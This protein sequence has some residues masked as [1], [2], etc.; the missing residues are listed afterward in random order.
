MKSYQGGVLFIDMLGFGALTNGHLTLGAVECEPWKVDPN[1]ASPHQLI[2]AQILL[3]FR[4]ALMRTKNAYKAVRVAQLSDAAFLWSEDIG[5][6]A[7]A[8][9]YVM[10]EAAAMGLLCRGGLAIGGVHEPNKPNN[11]LGA[12]IVGD[13]VTRAVS[14]EGKGKGMRIFTD[15]DTVRHVLEARPDEVFTP[16]VD[17]LSG[18]TIDEWQWYVPS[19]LLREE[20]DKNKLQSQI[21]S[22]VTCH[23]MFRYSPKLSW[24]ATTSEGRRQIACSVVAVSD[25]MQRLSRNKGNFGFSVEH[26]MLANQG[27]SERTRQR[28]HETFVQ[29]L[30]RAIQPK[31]RK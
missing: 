2:A 11:S 27:R 23:T 7:D 14:H 1:G 18:I 8:G 15:E 9:R 22:L 3:A 4:R 25:A 21:E 26:L 28:V 29:E 10:H 13:A 31:E 6:L 17:P 16:L 19:P 12:F 20:H 30:L 5:A 24:S